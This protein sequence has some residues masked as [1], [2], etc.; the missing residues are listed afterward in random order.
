VRELLSL[1]GEEC[2]RGC[3][4]GYIATPPLMPCLFPRLPQDHCVLSRELIEA[5]SRLLREPMDVIDVL[6]SRSMMVAR[7]ACSRK[8]HT[9]SEQSSYSRVIMKGENAETEPQQSLS[10]KKSR[11]GVKA[12]CWSQ[13]DETVLL[14][15]SSSG[16]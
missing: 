5:C 4:G 16:R 15:A 11:V 2:E 14:A 7:R 1:T 12:P 13:R 3:K 10:G 8:R 6:M 9:D